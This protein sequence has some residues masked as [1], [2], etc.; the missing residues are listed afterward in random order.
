MERSNLKVLTNAFVSRI[1]VN[2]VGKEV[3]A[4]AV[5]FEHGDKIYEVKVG[6]EAILSAGLVALSY[7]RPF[8]RLTF[9][10]RTVKTPRILELSGIGDPDVLAKHGIEVLVDLPTVGTNV[11]EHSVIGLPRWR[12]CIYSHIASHIPPSIVRRRIEG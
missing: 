8:V 2:K 4:E 7:Q 9:R 6:K 12:A 11:Q 3:I 10:N 1:K 5:E